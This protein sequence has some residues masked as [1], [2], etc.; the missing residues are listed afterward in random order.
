MLVCDL[1][2]RVVRY[3]YEV[4][5]GVVVGVVGSIVFLHLLLRPG[6]RLG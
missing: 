3:P 2:G 4:P 6:A 1:L 5:V